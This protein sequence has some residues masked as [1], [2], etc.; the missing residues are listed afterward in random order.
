MSSTKS[1]SRPKKVPLGSSPALNAPKYG[2]S[3]PFEFSQWGFDKNKLSLVR[4]NK[5]P[6][7]LK[8][9]TNT[10]SIEIDIYKTVVMVIDMQNDFCHPKGWFG[11]KGIG[12]QAM[13][14][15]IP[16]LKKLLPAWRNLGGRVLW[17]NW[18]VRAD[19]LNLPPLLQFKSKLSANAQMDGVGYAESSPND[20][21]PSVVPGHWGAQVVDELILQA[22]DIQVY[23]HRLSGFWDNELDSILRMHGITTILFAG[24]NTDRC[25]FSTLQDAAF[26]G[27]DCI[28]IKDAC[29][30]PSPA[31]VSKAIYFLIEKLHGFISSSDS[32]T[33]SKPTKPKE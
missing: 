25:V 31:Y 20:L 33:Q 10:I 29:S 18:G 21:G 23:K 24:V 13:R 15:P 32:I 28:L 16:V 6:K 19:A 9:Q 1:K 14:K 17:L 8:L 12:V 2:A 3:G 4:E 7:K 22:Q 5:A 30:T 27:Y 26:I 11:Q